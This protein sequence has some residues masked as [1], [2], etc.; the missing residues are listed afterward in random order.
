MRKASRNKHAT[1]AHA[2]NDGPP[3]PGTK[4]PGTHLF[5]RAIYFFFSFQ[6]MKKQL[7]KD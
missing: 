7:L 6:V 1:V 5:F 2:A 4:L 3:D